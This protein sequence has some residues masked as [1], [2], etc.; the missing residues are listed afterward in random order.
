[1]EEKNDFTLL[2]VSTG[3]GVRYL[4]VRK[5]TSPL[6]N[7]RLPLKACESRSWDELMLPLTKGHAVQKINRAG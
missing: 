7:K 4:D 1:L 6:P 2:S 3:N 5:K